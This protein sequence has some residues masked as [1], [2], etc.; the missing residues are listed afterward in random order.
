[1]KKERSF[2][3]YLSI[4]LVLLLLA[5]TSLT[6]AYWDDLTKSTSGTDEIEIGT[7]KTLTVTGSVDFG[8]KKLIPEGAAKG[9]NDVYS[10]T[11]TYTVVVNEELEDYK[12][13][14][15]VVMGS[16]LLQGVPSE[17]VVEL[18]SGVGKQI[19]ITFSFADSTNVNNVDLAEEDVT[20]TITF[21]YKK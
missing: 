13:H 8:E 18:A 3:K 1:M 5:V 21:E 15:S 9:E 20:F 19:T 7:R 14:V 10:L 11:T 6:V 4:A 17:N 12:L 16:T 2:K